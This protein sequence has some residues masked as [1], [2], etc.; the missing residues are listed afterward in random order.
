MIKMNKNTNVTYF[1]GNAGSIVFQVP[2]KILNKQSI[3]PLVFAV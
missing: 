1:K 3:H 2:K